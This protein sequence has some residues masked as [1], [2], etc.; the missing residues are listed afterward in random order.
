MIMLVVV[1]SLDIAGRQD[2]KACGEG[3]ERLVGVGDRLG[4]GGDELGGGE[5]A[6]GGGR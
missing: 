6:G 3:R 4:G 5:H 1:R 2:T